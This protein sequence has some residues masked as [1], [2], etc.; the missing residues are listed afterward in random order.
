ME[1]PKVL[2]DDVIALV[3]RVVYEIV[4]NDGLSDVSPSFK[5]H[6]S[7]HIEVRSFLFAG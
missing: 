5:S 4:K 2:L 7:R 6:M 3:E 1:R